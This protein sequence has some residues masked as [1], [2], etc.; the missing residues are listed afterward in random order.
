MADLHP[1][2]QLVGP[3][4]ATI[5]LY[6][7]FFAD[8]QNDPFKGDYT[9]ALRP[10]SIPAANALTPA[11][12]STLAVN[13]R[14]QNVPTAFV[15]LHS[16]DLKLHIYL[17][18]DRFDP[19]FGFPASPFDDRLFIGKGELHHNHH[20]LVEWQVNYF[21]QTGNIRVPTADAIDAELSNNNVAD[22]LLGPFDA[23]AANTETIRV[24]YTCYIPPVYVPLFLA[25]PLTPRQAWETIR[26]QI[27]TDNRVEACTPLI[28]YLRCCLTVSNEMI[29]KETT[30]F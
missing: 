11:Q 21:H 9:E 5:A 14:N 15:L 13:C 30:G 22:V 17:Q 28:D 29:M 18:L 6:R 20:Q 4:Q 3:A 19:R 10:Y 12:V 27:V 7:N 24:R 16:D 26:A 23:G 1:P 2:P 8:A 25:E